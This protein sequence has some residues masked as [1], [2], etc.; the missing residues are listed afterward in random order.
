MATILLAWVLQCS[1]AYSAVQPYQGRELLGRAAVSLEEGS[2]GHDATRS[3]FATCGRGDIE[4][5]AQ[6]S[7]EIFVLLRLCTV[8]ICSRCC[9]LGSHIHGRRRGLTKDVWRRSFLF[10]TAGT[11]CAGNRWSLQ[12][13]LSNCNK[14]CSDSFEDSRLFL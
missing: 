1:Q 4:H 2:G 10:L 11:C 8:D 12:L 3:Q 5:L 9:T 14:R 7:R 6:I 13:P